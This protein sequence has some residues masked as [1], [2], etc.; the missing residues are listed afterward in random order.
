MTELSDC[1]LDDPVDYI[2]TKV[3]QRLKAI[4]CSLEEITERL[5][6]EDK[7]RLIFQ[8]IGRDENGHAAKQ[9]MILESRASISIGSVMSR[10]DKVMAL[11]ERRHQNVG[12]ID[13]VTPGHDMP[14]SH[15]QV[16]V[17]YARR[18][19]I[20]HADKAQDALRVA[21]EARLSE[22]K[23]ASRSNVENQPALN[24]GQIDHRECLGNGV[25]L[26]GHNLIIENTT[27]PEQVAIALTGKPVSAICVHE[28]LG[29]ETIMSIEMANN[30]MPKGRR[31]VIVNLEKKWTRA[32]EI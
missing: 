20:D 31:T 7:T 13:P 32:S 26:K 3:E 9:H 16:S 6:H 5:I 14:L 30:D 29:D 12:G 25:W 10:I 22:K 11:Q 27:L 1:L 28:V 8:Y 4:G 21:I 17:F 18:L 23:P 2:K 24:V 19:K 15:L